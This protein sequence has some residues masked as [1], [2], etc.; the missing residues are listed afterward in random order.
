MSCYYI[1]DWISNSGAA[2]VITAALY[3]Y[4]RINKRIIG[5]ANTL[6]S[7]LNATLTIWLR[8]YSEVLSILYL[9][10]NDNGIVSLLTLSRH[11]VSVNDSTS[12]M[13]LTVTTTAGFAAIEKQLSLWI[14]IA[15]MMRC[16]CMEAVLKDVGRP[17]SLAMLTELSATPRNLD[18]LA[19][20]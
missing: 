4:Y 7:A 5:T 9:L 20:T 12:A 6:F 19:R 15:P 1:C 2:L 11:G 17:T 3:R 13:T 16:S 18:E 8:A 14:S 10:R